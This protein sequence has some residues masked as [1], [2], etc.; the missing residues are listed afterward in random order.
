MFVINEDQSIHITRGDIAT[1]AVSAVMLDNTNY[2]FKVG[3]VVRIKVYE[4]KQCNCVVLRKL[5]DVTEETTTVNIYLTTEDTR[6][7]ETI[8]KPKDYW[9]EIELNPE[10]NPQTIVGYDS[11]GPKVFRL[12]PEGDAS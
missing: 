9:Y 12:Y 4:K 6:I 5:V 1:I 10:T 2:V 7:G 11:V 3:D 8:H